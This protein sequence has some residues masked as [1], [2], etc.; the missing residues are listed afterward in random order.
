VAKFY[1]FLGLAPLDQI[2]VGLE[3]R[4]DFLLAGNLFSLN[5]PAASLVDDAAT[6]IAV[7]GNLLP[8]L[9]D[10]HARDHIDP[11]NAFGLFDHLACIL[12]YLPGDPQQ[13]AV[14]GFLLLLALL[15]GHP[16]ELLHA[17]LSA[18]GAI[19]KALYP[20]G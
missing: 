15:G 18:A 9:V 5:H 4:V 8:Q 1:R 11:L 3:D 12:H 16:L 10:H 13:F 19:G 14:L 17:A 7:G 6:Q 20:V 2:G